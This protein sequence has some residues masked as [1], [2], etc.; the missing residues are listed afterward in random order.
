[1]FGRDKSFLSRHLRNI[2]ESCELDRKT[3]VAF[4]ATV[5]KEGERQIERQIKNHSFVDGNKRIAA[6]LFLWFMEKNGLL[7]THSGAKK[8]ADT[9][10]VAMTLMIAESNPKEML[11]IVTMTINLISQ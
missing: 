9:T 3:T 5:Q 6:A 7:Y 1:M 2:Y 4:F 10:L 8:I 11:M